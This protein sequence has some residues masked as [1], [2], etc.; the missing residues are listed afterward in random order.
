MM[1]S[2]QWHVISTTGANP[3]TLTSHKLHPLR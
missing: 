1:E 3:S 2:T